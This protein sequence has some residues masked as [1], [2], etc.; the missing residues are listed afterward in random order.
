M[1]FK[2]LEIFTDQFKFTKFVL[3]KLLILDEK[4][5]IK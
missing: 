4:H 2:N 5:H 1:D 3:A